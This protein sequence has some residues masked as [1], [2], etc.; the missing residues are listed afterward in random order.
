MLPLK[1]FLKECVNLKISPNS[2]C[3]KRL[4][5]RRKIPKSYYFDNVEYIRRGQTNLTNVGNAKRTDDI[6]HMSASVLCIFSNMLLKENIRDDFL[7]RCIEKRSF[8]LLDKFE[9][10]EV[11]S[12]L[13]CLSKIRLETKLYDS[14]ISIIKRKYEYL[15]T[16]NLAMLISAYSKRNEKDLIVFLKEEFKKKI[17]TVHNIVE[18]SMI[19]NA[20]VKCK[21]YDEELL[22]KLSFLIVDI[23]NHTDNIHVRDLCVIVFCYSSI[24]EYTNKNIV[25]ILAGK[26][27]LLIDETNLVDLCRIFCSYM[28]LRM[29]SHHILRVS[30]IR[31]KSVLNKSSIDEVIN[32]IHFL[33]NLKKI[34]ESSEETSLLNSKWK[35]FDEKE[36]GYSINWFYLFN[37]IINMFNEKL[38][39]VSNTLDSNQISNVFYFYSRYNILMSPLKLELFINKIKYMD[40]SVES[41]IYVLYSLIILLKNLEDNLVYNFDTLD[42]NKIFLQVNDVPICKNRKKNNERE[43]EPEHEH[44]PNSE[45]AASYISREHIRNIQGE[46]LYCLQKWEQ[47]ILLFMNN[48]ERC[49]MQDITKIIHVLFVLDNKSTSFTQSIKH[50]VI[51]KYKS[52]NE[53]TANTL[54]FYFRNFFKVTEDD[55]LVE[56]L[57]LKIIKK[58]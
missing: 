28:N 21:I 34:I 30:A 35:H 42:V 14:F 6:K 10:D 53:A 40:L 26:I 45:L 2:Y 39:S 37:Y 29:N 8:E 46:L 9:I 15:N 50:Y 27:T 38:T 58:K 43:L 51:F 32:C 23:I 18:I 1:T 7:W 52:I 57:K 36:L 12:F 4:V 47:E 54:L 33:P 55:D 41:K 31:L 24:E 20:L 13:F 19:L 56:I 11:A 48:Y 25:K 3:S 5:S 22:K 44:K 16:S 49:S 17:Y